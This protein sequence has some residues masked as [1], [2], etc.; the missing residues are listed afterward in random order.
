[1]QAHGVSTAAVTG[2]I[3]DQFSTITQA[4]LHGLGV[5]LLPDYLAEQDLATGR[6]CRAWGGSTPSPGA[7]HLVWPKEKSRDPALAE[8]PRLAGHAGRT[9]RS[10][11]ALGDCAPGEKILP[12]PSA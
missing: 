12:Y 4:A 6:L 10:P 11:A 5:A 2:Q 1:L 8:V 3:F 7:Y 9:R